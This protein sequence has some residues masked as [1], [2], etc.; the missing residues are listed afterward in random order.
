MLKRKQE[1]L[2]ALV[3]VITVFVT[4]ALPYAVTEAYGFEAKKSI[5]LLRLVALTIF[6]F[7][8]LIL[9]VVRYRQTGRHLKALREEI[10]RTKK[11]KRSRDE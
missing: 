9:W 11:R 3:I 6:S 5:L 4:L 10:E 1:F 7:G 8:L 2:I